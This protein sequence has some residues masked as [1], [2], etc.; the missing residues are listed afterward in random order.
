M[1]IWFLSCSFMVPKPDYCVS[2]TQC[3]NLFGM[4]YT[5]GSEGYC[6]LFT[7]HPRCQKTIPEDLYENWEKHSG[8]YI[9]G[10]LFKHGNDQ[11][12]IVASSL[13]SLRGDFK[14]FCA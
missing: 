5:C 2:S 4:G 12:N 14:P 3:E 1:I 13:A 11:A 9:I 8:S 7:P 10:T 6:D